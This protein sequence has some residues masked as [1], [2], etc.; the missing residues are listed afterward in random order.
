[1]T[2]HTTTTPKWYP[3]SHHDRYRTL[4]IVQRRWCRRPFRD[5]EDIADR[6]IFLDGKS[7]NDVPS[8]LLSIGEAVNG[9]N[10]YFGGCIGGLD[11]CLNGDF[12]F[13]APLTVQLSYFDVVQKAL[14]RRVSCRFDA[15][16]FLKII[17]SDDSG[18]DPI[19]RKLLTDPDYVG[20]YIM[21]ADY[22][23]E[24]LFMND[25]LGDGSDAEIALWTKKYL[26]ALADEPFDCDE[27]RP[28]FDVIL[29]IF[30]RRGAKLVPANEEHT[31]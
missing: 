15:E 17:W 12:G 18:D 22:L 24:R 3:L 25:Y 13:R 28:F 9:P 1:M 27:Y 23:R 14:D 11:D 10:G 30:E 20:E 6:T 8:F 4:K 7:I 31:E 16:C 5:I 21:N 26:A 2:T 29:G 19:D